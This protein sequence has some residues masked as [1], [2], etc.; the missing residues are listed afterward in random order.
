[1]A[2][3]VEEF[4]RIKASNYKLRFQYPTE[5][6][7]KK[8]KI[9]HRDLSKW[10]RQRLTR[11]NKNLADV[12]ADLEKGAMRVEDINEDT[13]RKLEELLKNR[14]IGYANAS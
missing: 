11:Q 1:M 7:R 2:R 14:G 6:Q 8:L 10:E 9:I 3:L 13:I 12:V 4:K 5:D